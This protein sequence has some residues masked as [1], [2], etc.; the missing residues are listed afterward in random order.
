MAKTQDIRR[1]SAV[2]G[3]ANLLTRATGLLR[4]MAFA[5]AFGAGIQADAFN[6]AFRIGNLFRELFAEG[7]LSNAFV[8][9]Y[10]SVEESDGRKSAYALVNAFMGVLLLSVGGVTIL[11]FVAAEPLVWAVASGFAKDPEKFDLSVRLS[12]VLSPFVATVSVASVFMGMLNL[13]GKFFLP[14]I[15]PMFFNASVIA[16]CIIGAKVELPFEPIMLV[17]VA[18]LVG[19]TAQALVQLPI[20]MRGGFRFAPNLQGHPALKRLIKFIGPA[21]IAISV[22]QL[23][24]LIETQL[25]SR[26]GD[27]AVSWLLYSFRIAHLPFSI[28]SGAV[29]VASLAGLSVLAAQDKWDRFRTDLASALNLNSFLLF[30]SAVGLFMLATPITALFFERG[31]FTASDTAQTAAMLQMYA[32][33]LMGIGAQRILVPVF[34]TLDDPKTPMWAGIATLVVKLPLALWLLDLF[35]LRGLPLSHAI[36]VSGEV[37][38]LIWLLSRRIQGG[39]LRALIGPQLR[40]LIASGVMGAG[41]WALEGRIPGVPGLLLSVA[42]GAAL[43]VFSSEAI[44]LREAR[45][46]LSR[47]RRPKG[48]PPTVDSDTQAL[49]AKLS[50]TPVTLDAELWQIHGTQASAQLVAEGGVLRLEFIPA[51]DAPKVSPEPLLISAIMRIGGGPPTLRGLWLG[52]QALNAVNDQ[53]QLGDAPGPVLPVEPAQL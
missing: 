20:L 48:L 43:F 18:A 12:R 36:L 22:I 15:M 11:T 34:Y 42:L 47:L 24:I 17:A 41:L 27:G 21:L 33:A 40:I 53:I 16:A 51:A 25:A 8:P 46:I 35:G 26:Q 52:E 3:A 10:A 13:R 2:V 38:V 31:A 4:E 45:S 5:A 28:V 1:N 14:A 30:P 19:G 7:A 37:V 44:G 23:H 49:L 39:L 6:A 9:L 50:G 32:V 29:G